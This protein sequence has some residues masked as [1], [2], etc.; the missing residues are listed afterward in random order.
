MTSKRGGVSAKRDLVV[1]TAAACREHA[2][3]APGE[4]VL[5]AVSAGA[6]STALA[7]L[8]AHLGEEGLPLDLV[9]GHVDH[10]W[11]G[12]EAAHADAACVRHL[13]SRLG[14][15][16]FLSP[17]PP[18]P[19]ASEDAA[20]RWRYRALHRMAEARGIGVVATGHHLGDQAETVLMR[21]ERGSGRV[22]LRGIPRRRPLG[23]EAA[24]HVVRPLLDVEPAALRALLVEVGLPWLDD[25]TNR[26]VSRDRARVRRR[27][28]ALEERGAAA[29]RRLAA[30]AARVEAR[31]A[32]RET[33]LQGRL[34]PAL[35]R[36]PWAGA[37][38]APR[39]LVANLSP[40]D[41]DLVM[42]WLGAAIGADRD[43]PFF[44]RRHLRRIQALLPD[45]GA[46]DLPR[47]HRVHVTGGTFWLRRSPPAAGFERLRLHREDGPA[48]AFDLAEF[49]GRCDP[50][51][52]ALD[53]QRL[54]PTPHLRRARAGDRFLPW[55]RHGGRETLLD[56]FL[57]KQ[58]L[59][60]WLRAEQ[61]VLD[62]RGEVAWVVGVRVDARH[63]VTPATRRVARVDVSMD[64]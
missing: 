63:A 32:R 39:A 55:S 10:G 16:L 20:R 28:A 60:A 59:P 40:P 57:A 36:Y 64:G 23:P 43:G 35:R 49:L 11:R 22:G 5:V 6:D 38:G 19:V 48:E 30:F 41:L 34:A 52:A 21:L 4:R 45:G 47:G 12:R 14:L 25:P 53:A 17:E 2:L 33:R 44:T 46:L 29:T 15:E 42:R 50:H 9:L 27:L 54:G 24:V 18:T 7:W 1:R 51:Q 61:P 3:L 56:T 62:A 8:L 58:G 26:D 13:A 31:L 37:V